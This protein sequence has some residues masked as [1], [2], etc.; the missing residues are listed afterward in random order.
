LCCCCV[1]L[2]LPPVCCSPA[3]LFCSTGSAWACLL[4]PCLFA[5]CLFACCV[6]ACCLSFAGVRVGVR[7]WS[8]VLL[9]GASFA[10]VVLSPG[11]VLGFSVVR[12]FVCRVCLF[13]CFFF[14]R[15]GTC[16]GFLLFACFFCSHVLCSP[17]CCCSPKSVLELCVLR[18]FVCSPGF[19]VRLPVL[20]ARADSGMCSCSPV[21]R[22]PVCCS[23]VCFC[24]RLGPWLVVLLLACV[25]P[26]A[27]LFACL[28]L[29]VRARVGIVCSSPVCV[30]ACFC[31]SHACFAR[32]GP[33]WNV[34]LL[35]CLL[36]AC[37]LLCSPGSV[38][39]C[40]AARL[41]CSACFFVRLFVFVR[42][43]PLW[44]C[45]LFAVSCSPVLCSPAFV[46]S[47]GSVLKCVV[48]PRVVSPVPCLPVFFVD[49]LGPY[50]GF[51][52]RLFFVRL[53][54]VPLLVWLAWVRARAFVV[55]LFLFRRLVVRLC[56]VVRLGPF[57]FLLFACL[58]L[59]CFG[60]PVLLL[61]AGVRVGFVCCSPV[62]CCMLFVRLCALLAWARLGVSC[63][64]P[65]FVS[66][67]FCSPV[68]HSPGSVLGFCCLPLVFRLF[69]VRL[70]CLLAWVRFRIVCCSPVC[71]YLLVGR[72][73][74]LCLLAWVRF[75]IVCC[76]PVSCSPVF[77]SPVL[78]ARL[79]P[80]W[81]CLVFACV[82][83]PVARL[84]CLLA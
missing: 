17:V 84:L 45:L 79:G 81:N 65:A 52:V 80:F 9:S 4:F 37:L 53:L 56:F 19:V 13:A 50:W 1:P 49:C 64:S 28:F 67:V 15:L 43:G 25:V 21:C 47:P 51:V 33:F 68:F 77:C 72:R 35:A 5:C 8:H 40:V 59:A 11:S 24:A 26:S 46:C 36:V 57:A 69:C 39:G 78:F 22:S 70:F 10:C 20:L 83:S 3:V 63:C 31:C 12:L 42:P 18:L 75:G 54:V 62:C 73:F 7:C 61:L 71:F 32:P 76:S 48:A 27:C 58:V 82:A 34:L 30:F 29:F 74:V 23:P 2:C 55:R 66:P 44:N 38:F 41:Y 6:F 14:A 16:W 60:S